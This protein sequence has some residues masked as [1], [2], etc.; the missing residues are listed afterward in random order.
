MLSYLDEEIET[1][2]AQNQELK[3]E[4]QRQAKRLELQQQPNYLELKYNLKEARE[5]RDF[6]AIELNQSQNE[7]SVL[8][9]E[10][11]LHIA[12]LEQ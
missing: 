6:C 5:E 10:M 3:N 11:R 12:R 9:L 1:E 2:I 8:K 4:Q 7:F